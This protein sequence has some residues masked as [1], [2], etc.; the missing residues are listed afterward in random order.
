MSLVY[1]HSRL[2]AIVVYLLQSREASRDT[3]NSL[4]LRHC[5]SLKG[6]SGNFASKPCFKK[7][8]LT[9]IG[10]LIIR[11]VFRVYDIHN[12]ESEA[13]V[14]LMIQASISRA[15]KPHASSPNSYAAEP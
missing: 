4:F 3:N 5:V 10:A 11:T 2:P 7:R 15:L 13:I 6:R 12:K 8:S 14:V 9:T 1:R